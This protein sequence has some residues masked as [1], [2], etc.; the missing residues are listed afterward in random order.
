MKFY[1]A[2]RNHCGFEIKYRVR[3]VSLQEAE[4]KIFK[5]CGEHLKI[6]EI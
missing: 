4:E 3:A 2:K 5:M 6:K 1:E